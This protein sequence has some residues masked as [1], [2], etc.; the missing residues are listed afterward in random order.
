MI[1]CGNVSGLLRRRH[2]VDVFGQLSGLAK[3]QT[4]ASEPVIVPAR[5]A[6]SLPIEEA[7]SSP[8]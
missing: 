4:E 6:A 1:G 8:W 2:W 7:E 5:I 3:N